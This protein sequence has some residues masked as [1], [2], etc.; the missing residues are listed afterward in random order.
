MSTPRFNEHDHICTCGGTGDDGCPR[1]LDLIEGL[2]HGLNFRCALCAGFDASSMGWVEIRSGDEVLF[3]PFF[4]ERSLGHSEF[5]GPDYDGRGTDRFELWREMNALRERASRGEIVERR[6]GSRPSPRDGRRVADAIAPTTSPLP[7]LRRLGRGAPV[8]TPKVERPKDRSRRIV[9]RAFATTPS[10]GPESPVATPGPRSLASRA[11]ATTTRSAPTTRPAPTPQAAPASPRPGRHAPIEATRRATRATRATP[12]ATKRSAASATQPA[13]RY[14]AESGLGV[15]PVAAGAVIVAGGFVVA[16]LGDAVRTAAGL[17]V[18]AVA[19]VTPVV[20]AQAIARRRLGAAPD[21]SVEVSVEEL[22]TD[23]TYVVDDSHLD[24][25]E[26]GATVPSIAAQISA[27]RFD[28][29]V[30]ERDAHARAA[31]PE[32]VRRRHT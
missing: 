24:D 28:A 6:P 10:P 18:P 14:T 26:G 8:V 12:R 25:W 9:R 22:D 17:I 7:A 21:A 2:D 19:L 3:V 15:L 1:M 32:L 23:E 5:L 4:D 20:V 13:T 11:F 29:W 16:V 27:A 31:H 30:R